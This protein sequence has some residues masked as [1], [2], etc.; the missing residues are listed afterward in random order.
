MVSAHALRG[1]SLVWQCHTPEL[2][3]ANGVLNT[4]RKSS[5]FEQSRAEFQERSQAN[6]L[7]ALRASVVL[8]GQSK[9]VWKV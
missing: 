9:E 8:S 7:N 5:G 3:D 1:I 4:L 6:V 2:R